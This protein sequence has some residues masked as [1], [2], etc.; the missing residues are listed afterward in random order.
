MF[1]NTSVFNSLTR[2][3][4]S[5]MLLAL[6]DIPLYTVT[7]VMANSVFTYLITNSPHLAIIKICHIGNN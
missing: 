3:I 4:S 5:A 7:P 2:R 6:Q 1:R